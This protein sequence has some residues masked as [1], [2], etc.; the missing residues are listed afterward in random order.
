M[1]MGKTKKLDDKNSRK[2]ENEEHIV[3]VGQPGEFYLLNTIPDSGTGLS[4]VT[5]LFNEIK[6]TNWLVCSMLLKVMIL[7]L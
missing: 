5:S 3:M 6:D 4:I 2:V 1:L 7:Q